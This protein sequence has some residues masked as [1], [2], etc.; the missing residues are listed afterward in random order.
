MKYLKYLSCL[1]I[2]LSA[3]VSTEA[4]AQQDQEMEDV[5]FVRR[6]G[7]RRL[8]V[9]DV[10][11]V[12]SA[13]RYRRSGYLRRSGRNLICLGLYFLGVPPGAIARIYR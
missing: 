6:I 10:A 12:T 1:A 8:D 13:V 9:L 5:D 2:A 11:A 3:L 4:I 7:H